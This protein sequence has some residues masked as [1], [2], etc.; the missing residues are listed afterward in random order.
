ME[1]RKPK[2]EL[3]LKVWMLDE[4]QKAVEK[5]ISSASISVDKD[6]QS[7]YYYMVSD[8]SFSTESF[9]SYDES[10]LFESK[11][12]LKKSIFGE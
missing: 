3:G 9:K 11:E 6:G 12:D 10:K 8:T 5:E 2:Y 4:N 1:V 7:V